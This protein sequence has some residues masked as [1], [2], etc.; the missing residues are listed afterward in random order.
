MYDMEIKISLYKAHKK[1]Y[2]SNNN[3][4]TSEKKRCGKF[5]QS[6]AASVALQQLNAIKG[7]QKVNEL[8][9]TCI[10]WLRKNIFVTTEVEYFRDC[11]DALDKGVKCSGVYTIKPDHLPPFEASSNI[12]HV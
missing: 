11:Q 7:H 4:N 1:P 2:E 8:E 10:S 5:L 3:S 9:Y 6:S 12:I